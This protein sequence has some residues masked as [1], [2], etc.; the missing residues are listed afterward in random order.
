MRESYAVSWSGGKDSALS[1][2]RLWQQRGA[3]AALVTTL[4]DDGSRTRSHRLRPEVLRAQVAAIGA[5]IVEVATSLTDYRRNFSAA[6]AQLR[7]E[8]GVVAVGFGDIDLQAH[9]I[10]CRSV[11]AD[12]GLDCLHPIWDE[13]RETLLREFF[14]AGFV[15]RIVAV[16]EDKLDARLLGRVLDDAVVDEFRRAGIDLCGEAGEYHTVVVDGPC[17]AQPLR[18]REDGRER[19]DGYCFIDFALD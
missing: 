9:R 10:W 19:A 5:P 4:V 6:L 7:D 2:W 8:A 12:L 3:P 18:L 17:F 14:D 16:Q 13:P 1:L 15:T 11:C